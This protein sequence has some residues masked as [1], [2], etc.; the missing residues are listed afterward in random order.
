MAIFFDRYY[1]MIELISGLLVEDIAVAVDNI[2][3]I[4]QRQIFGSHNSGGKDHY[5]VEM[6]AD[7]MRR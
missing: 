4:E 7:S 5:P 6:V 1:G 3:G 2:V